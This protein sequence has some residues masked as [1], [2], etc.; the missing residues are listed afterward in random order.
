MPRSALRPVAEAD[1]ISWGKSALEPSRESSR[2]GLPGD[3]TLPCDLEWSGSSAEWCELDPCVFAAAFGSEAGATLLRPAATGTD[4]FTGLPEL[5]PGAGIGADATRRFVGVW[6]CPIAE[7]IGVAPSG[8]PFRTA[9]GVA[10]AP[11]RDA[12]VSDLTGAV[13]VLLC[14]AAGFPLEAAFR[15]VAAASS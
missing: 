4:A 2:C 8:L 11:L 15:T 6:G 14:I 7:W 9:R 10:F 5:V 1:K 13:G 3:L 12:E